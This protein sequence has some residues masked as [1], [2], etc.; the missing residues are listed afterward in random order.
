MLLV[1]CFE[2]CGLWLIIN[3]CLVVPFTTVLQSL[4]EI[5]DSRLYG[6]TQVK[7]SKL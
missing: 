3:F 2:G 5:Q 7:V 6:E 1:R 4:S